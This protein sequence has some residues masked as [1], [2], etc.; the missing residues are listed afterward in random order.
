MWPRRWY[1]DEIVSRDV[2]LPTEKLAVGTPADKF[3]GVCQSRR[4]TESRSES[5]PDQRA[6]SSM[7]PT[8]AFMDLLGISLSSSVRTHFMST[9][10]AVPRLYKLSPTGTYPLLRLKIRAAS[11]LFSSMSEGSLCSFMKSMKVTR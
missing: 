5:L 9:P 10:D 1:G 2:G 3:F 8:H 7:V 11:A 4:P 6:R